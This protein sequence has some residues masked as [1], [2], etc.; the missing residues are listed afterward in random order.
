M[1]TS[2]VLRARLEGKLIAPATTLSLPLW[3]ARVTSANLLQDLAISARKEKVIK[4]G[5]S[6]YK[7]RQK[8]KYPDFHSWKCLPQGWESSVGE[9]HEFGLL[10]DGSAKTK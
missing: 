1:I 6:K 3:A 4:Q 7:K 10:V 8:E 2:F 5:S 9:D